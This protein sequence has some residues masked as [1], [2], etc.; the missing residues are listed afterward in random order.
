MTP[1]C[2]KQVKANKNY[3]QNTKLIFSFMKSLKKG[4]RIE[5]N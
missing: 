4:K 1:H 2:K 3:K 5:L